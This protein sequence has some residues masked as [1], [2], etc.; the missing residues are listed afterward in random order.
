MGKRYYDL[1]AKSMPEG[2][3]RPKKAG[4]VLL[5]PD[6]LGDVLNVQH[7]VIQGV[8]AP[9]GQGEGDFLLQKSADDIDFL[10]PV[11][12]NGKAAVVALVDNQLA[13]GSPERRGE[14]GAD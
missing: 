5:F 6:R 10:N 8:D 2:F 12:G 14:F 7:A 1:R 9:V 13:E 3:I 4:I 11:L